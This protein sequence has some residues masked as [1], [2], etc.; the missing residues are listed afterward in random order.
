M[1]MALKRYEI[2]EI[3]L[4]KGADKSLPNHE[5]TSVQELLFRYSDDKLTTIFKSYEKN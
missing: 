3:L 1:A 4:K 2:V 5:G